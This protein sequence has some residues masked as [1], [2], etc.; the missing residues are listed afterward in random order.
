MVQS[1]PS[2]NFIARWIPDIT[3][4]L[5]RFVRDDRG[6]GNS[7]F[8][9]FSEAVAEQLVADG[10]RN[11]HRAGFL[12]HERHGD[13]SAHG[14]GVGEIGQRDFQ[15][16]GTE[17]CAPVGFNADAVLFLIE[18]IEAAPLA[19]TQADLLGEG[20]RGR[21][22]R[23]GVLAHVQDFK[24][25][26]DGTVFVRRDTCPGAL[27]VD[28]AVA[29]NFGK[30]RKSRAYSDQGEQGGFHARSQRLDLGFSSGGS[31]PEGP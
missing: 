3:S 7:C 16:A 28:G 13:F 31:I 14:D 4:P 15:R 20:A 9:Y 30:G 2:P 19:F 18:E 21:T 23:V 11:G 29:R 17:G 12:E 27:N 24:E 26:A 25:Y 10:G 1:I 6:V 5:A 8:A 22:Q